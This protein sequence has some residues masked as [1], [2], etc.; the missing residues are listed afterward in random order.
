MGGGGEGEGKGEG[1][2]RGG[3]CPQRALV[4]GAASFECAWTWLFCWSAL[5][6]CVRTRTS[7]VLAA[8]AAAAPGGVEAHL[9]NAP[10]TVAGMSPVP[11]APPC[12]HQPSCA[13]ALPRPCAASVLPLPSRAPA[14]APAHGRRNA[15][16]A[17]SIELGVPKGSGIALRPYMAVVIGVIAA[18]VL[19]VAL[20]I[21]RRY[22]VRSPTF[23][24]VRRRLGVG[25]LLPLSSR[26]PLASL[27]LALAPGCP[28][29]YPC[30]LLPLPL[31]MPLAA[32]CCCAQLP[33]AGRGAAARCA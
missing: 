5:W 11:L 33:G 25:A 32:H 31:L 4:Q 27:A 28:S 22:F 26:L 23:A 18:I 10:P 15:P 2:K 20:L 7:L 3:R 13:R 29:P 8:P 14:P 1:G 9:C 17:Y 16:Y 24:G 21:F 30:P 6:H 12:S 19:C